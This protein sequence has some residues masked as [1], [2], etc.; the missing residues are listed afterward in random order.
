MISNFK[1]PLHVSRNYM[2]LTVQYLSLQ[3]QQWFNVEGNRHLLEAESVKESG[4]RMEQILNSFT[5]FLI[6]A[7]VS[8]RRHSAVFVSLCLSSL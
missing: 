3:M 8:L 2:G 4:D 7:N 5:A 6:E 1:Q